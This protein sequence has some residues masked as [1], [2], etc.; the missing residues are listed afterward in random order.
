MYTT[1]GS[2]DFVR[3]HLA[4]V[5]ELERIRR[6]LGLASMDILDFGGGHSPLSTFLRLYGLATNYRLAVADI[7]ADAIDA[8]R[9]E[10]PLVSKHLLAQDGS[11]P[12]ADRSFDVAVSSDVFEH[13]PPSHRQP[14]ASELHRVVRHAQVHNVPCDGDEFASS[15]ADAAYQAWHLKHFG[16]PEP[17]TAEHLENGVP[18]LAELSGMFPGYEI[19]GIANAD[20]WL[21]IMKDEGTNPS[22]FARLRRGLSY[23]HSG[24]RHD[25][26]PPFKAAFV[27]GMS[28]RAIDDH[29]RERAG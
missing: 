18:A 27:S 26:T 21:T 11:L 17:W 19:Q 22:A 1:G 24:W 7:A 6:E 23:A 2:L 4:M 8:A 29:G 20:R 28:K 12:F 15:S 25:R 9:L 3:R 14:W 16:T 10:P 13:I 5:N